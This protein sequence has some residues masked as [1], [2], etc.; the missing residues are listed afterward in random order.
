[1]SA[2]T[3][4]VKL[5]TSISAH[6]HH[7]SSMISVK[8]GTEGVHV[9]PFSNLE[10]HENWCSERHTLLKGINTTLPVLSSFSE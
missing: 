1:L 3:N 7:I 9:M 4:F 6:T 5:H 2:S 10:F 8:S